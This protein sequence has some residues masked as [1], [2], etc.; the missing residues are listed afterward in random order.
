MKNSVALSGLSKSLRKPYYWLWRII[1]KRF[2]ENHEYV[3]HV[4]YGQR[5][6]APWFHLDSGSPFSNA[7]QK[8]RQTGPL[9]VSLDRC[10][11]L[12]QF[13]QQALSRT[14]EWAECGVYTGGTAHLIASILASRDAGRHLHLF[15]SFAGMPESAVPERDY[16]SQGDFADTSLEAVQARLSEFAAICVFHK[17]FM[18]GTFAEVA[19]IPQYSFV[20]VDVDIYPSV[21]ACL[22]WFWPRMTP[23]GIM[24]FDDYGFFPYRY[25]AKQAID[26]FFSEEPNPLI[27][28]PTGQAIAIKY[29][30]AA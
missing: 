22:E 7:I 25:A 14:G 15:D 4:P 16:H 6:L 30:G 5:I 29:T 17:G 18:P 10:Y 28:L 2:F 19:N 1:Q 26:D 3:L 12:W 13:A 24:I 20:H 21:M 27:V 9:V 8:T 11:M 23:G